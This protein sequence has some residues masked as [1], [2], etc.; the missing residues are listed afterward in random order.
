MSADTA[1]AAAMAT[2]DQWIARVRALPELGKRAAPDVADMIESE[3]RRTMGAGQS[4]DGTP[5]KPTLEGE[6]P[7]TGSPKVL[8][9]AA[10]SGTVYVRL[11]GIE[12]AHHLGRV[13]GRNAR[14]LIPVDVLPPLMAA[15]TERILAQHF[16]DTMAGTERGVP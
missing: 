2:L 10:I 1:N 5:L 3:L 4:P 12:A 14:H 16:A 7:L 6:V 8:G 15:A 13:R 9:V 11:T